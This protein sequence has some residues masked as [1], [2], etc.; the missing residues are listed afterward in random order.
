MAFLSTVRAAVV[1]FRVT[2]TD[3]LARGRAAWGVHAPALRRVPVTPSGWLVLAASLAAWY[4]GARLGWLELVL[5]AATGLIALLLCTGLVVG[6]MALSVTAAPERDRVVVGRSTRCHVVV[7]N[8]ARRRMLPIEVELPIGGRAPATFDVPALAAGGTFAADV[9]LL[10]DRRAVIPVGPA[11]TVRGDPLGLLRRSVSWSEVCEVFVHPVT[12]PLEP[13][14]AGL[15]RDLDG[16]TT[17]DMSMSDLAFH[18]LRDYAPGDDR[19]HIHWRSSAKLGAAR[20]A[21]TFLVRQFLDTRRAHL[22]VLVDGDGGAYGDV[23]DFETAVSVGASVV[24]RA[25]E[26]EIDTTLLVADQLVH[27][28]GARRSLDACSRAGQTTASLA[29]L[30]TRGVLVAP[31]A[32]I[33]LFVTGSAPSFAAL[34]RV[35]ARFQPEVRTFAVRVDPTAPTASVAG[36]AALTVLTLRSLTD[37]P[38]LLSGGTLR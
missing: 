26:D 30:A 38:A 3:A 20:P 10:T 32:T 31:D 27:K 2:A 14:G 36:S 8:R 17:N 13:L 7:T 24:L 37:L 9:E 16:Y 23:D 19:R 15:L 12:T 4:A 25:V 6:R 28:G 5:V 34:T 22:T 21:G 1:R 11:T 35:A 33:A 18:T 29:D